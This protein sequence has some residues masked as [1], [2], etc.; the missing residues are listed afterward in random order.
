MAKQVTTTIIAPASNYVTPQDLTD[1]IAAGC[2]NI[3]SLVDQYP[4]L[5][6]VEHSTEQVDDNMIH[7]FITVWEDQALYD[8][9]RAEASISSDLS[10][11]DSNYDVETNIEEV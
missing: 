2:P 5:T 10:F 8:E 7:T 6:S 11:L 9:C 1:E 3:S 4:G